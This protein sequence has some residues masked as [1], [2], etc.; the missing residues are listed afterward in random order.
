MK[1]CVMC[2]E[3]ETFSVEGGFERERES[4]RRC[5]YFKDVG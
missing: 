3:V 2:S 1:F 5:Y 4:E